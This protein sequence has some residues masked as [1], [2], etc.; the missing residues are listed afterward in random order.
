MSAWLINKV[1]FSFD[2]NAYH[3]AEHVV[4]QYTPLDSTT[5]GAKQV[6]I[7]FGATSAIH[8]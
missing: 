2:A 4:F 7:P 8:T 1:Y 3:S 5:S 6:A